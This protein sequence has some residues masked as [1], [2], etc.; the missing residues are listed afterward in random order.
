MELKN[1]KENEYLKFA[2]NHKD[3]SIYQLPAWGKLKEQ[4]GWKTHL[5]GLYADNKL[6]GVTMLLQKVTPIKL[7]LFYA[8]RGFLIPLDNYNIFAEFTELLKKY[9]KKYKGFMVKVDPNVIYS[10][11]DENNENKKIIGK[12][13]YDNFIKLKYRHLGFTLNFETMQPRY[14][15]RFKL[16]SDYNETCQGFAKSTRKNIIK[17]ENMGVRTRLINDEEIDLF[18]SLL[19][20]TGRLKNFIVR[21][22]SYYQRMYDLMKDY[23][24]LYLTYIDLNIYHEYLTKEI[25]I[26]K[27]ELAN[28]EKQMTSNNVGNK[29]KTAH[30]NYNEHLTK[31]TKDLEI[32]QNLRK[33]HDKIY[34]GAL[35]SIFIGEEGIT[36]MS[37]TNNQY[38][39]F[40][41]KYS[42]YNEHI[43][44]CFKEGKK[45]CNFYGISGDMNPHGE[46]YSIYEIKKGFRP[47]IVELIGEFDLITNRFGYYLYKVALKGYK[48]LK[49]FKH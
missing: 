6:I 20:E 27:K 33:S 11:S 5:L 13:V 23:L 42:F 25:E 1:I 15:C 16:G 4:T 37:G 45:Y 31:L 48:F 43:K 10:L 7:S 41:P 8:P 3:I 38:K 18:V 17:T 22:A 21:P 35:M 49:K 29:L 32:A 12:Q 39:S 46:Y 47:E 28:I 9:L 2:L 19:Q 36:F 14:L 30:K 40:N 26:T 24:K 34:I 44:E